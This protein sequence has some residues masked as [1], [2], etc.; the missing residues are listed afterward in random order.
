MNISFSTYIDEF[1]DYYTE[2]LFCFYT[3]IN[4]E[5]FIHKAKS[6]DYVKLSR[7]PKGNKTIIKNT[8]KRTG[9]KTLRS[10]SPIMERV[11]RFKDYNGIIKVRLSQ[12][13][14]SELLDSISINW[15]RRYSNLSEQDINYMKD[16]E[17]FVFLDTD[18]VYEFVY[19]L[20]HNSGYMVGRLDVDTGSNPCYD[21]SCIGY[22][23]LYIVR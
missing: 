6:M 4:E 3:G 1:A 12:A 22:K 18:K 8:A 23:N 2:T 21:Y 11:E 19:R 16:T 13:Q 10:C 15:L 17:L 14:A 20:Y 5:S 7:V 9:T